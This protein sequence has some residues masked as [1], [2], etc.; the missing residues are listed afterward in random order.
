MPVSAS[1]PASIQ[2]S[3][4]TRLPAKVSKPTDAAELEAE[5][6]A[7]KVMRM[8]EAG[9]RPCPRRRKPGEPRPGVP[10]RP[11]AFAGARPTRARR[12]PLAEDRDACARRGQMER[13]FG[14]NFGNVRIHTGMPPR[15]R[16]PP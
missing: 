4:G 9:R 16:A 13:R 2:L 14:A 12:G 6:T 11:H 10:R 5:E 3:R 8:R 15:S 1:V 7:R